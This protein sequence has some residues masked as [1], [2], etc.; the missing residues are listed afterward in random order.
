MASPC[1]RPTAI[2]SFI[3]LDG[4]RQNQKRCLPIPPILQRFRACIRFDCVVARD[5]G[6]RLQ[7]NR[8]HVRRRGRTQRC[9]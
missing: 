6:F 8:L 9:E 2:L 5:S 3:P 1:G 7:H 4:K